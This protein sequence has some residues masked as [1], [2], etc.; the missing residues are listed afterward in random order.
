MAWV[1]VVLLLLAA[2]SL[3]YRWWQPA[4]DLSHPRILM[5]HM[6]REPVP[7]ARFNGLRVPPAQF[8]AQLAWLSRRGWTFRFLS[9]V[10]SS[11]VPPHTCVLTFDDGYAD[12]LLHALPIMQR[13]GACAT[14][15][16][17]EQ[18]VDND[19][20]VLKKAHHDEGELMAEPKL[21]DAQVETLL[22]SGCFEL[23]GHS[24]THANLCRLDPARSAAEIRDSK[25]ALEARFG[26][27]LYSFAYPFGLYDA[28]HVAQVR[29]AGFAAAVTTREG[30][31]T[32]LARERF[33]LQRIKVSG[34][35]GLLRFRLGLRLGPRGWV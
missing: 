26:V 35:H 9:E 7:G 17:V 12:N 30:V 16:L 10:M 23:G 8:E 34:R 27:R 4:V 31:S 11:P 13:Y 21:S 33:E 25:A 14:L 28:H 19:W 29:E 18:R 15:Y 24:V 3:R 22:A 1:T 6:V 2:G 20:S 32:D 5:Y